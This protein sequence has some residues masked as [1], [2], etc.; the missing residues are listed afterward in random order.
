VLK[1]D[2]CT[3]AEAGTSTMLAENVATHELQ[4]SVSAASGLP[5]SSDEAEQLPI[6]VGR[7]QNEHSRRFRPECSSGLEAA[8]WRDLARPRWGERPRIKFDRPTRYRPLVCRP[9][10][11]VQAVRQLD[12]A[13]LAGED[14]PRAIQ[15]MSGEGEAVLVHRTSFA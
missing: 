10:E 8:L 4:A 11:E 3:A 5:D 9:C 7:E 12:C 15:V 6:A 2:R 13:V 14:D 1:A